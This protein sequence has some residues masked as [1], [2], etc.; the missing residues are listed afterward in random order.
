MGRLEG[1][2]T[3]E[4][5]IKDHVTLVVNPPTAPGES[6]WV[7][8]YEDGSKKGGIAVANTY[9]AAI[10]RAFAFYT[11]LIAQ[12]SEGARQQMLDWDGVGM[13]L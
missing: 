6:T 4:A 10:N 7:C 5:F 8:Y 3:L 2:M 9:D 13:R 12:R 11:D 1:D